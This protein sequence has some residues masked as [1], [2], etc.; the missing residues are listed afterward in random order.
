[1]THLFPATY[2]IPSPHAVRE[3]ILL[4]HDIGVV[5]DSRLHMSGVNDV[6]LVEAE[7]GCY[8]LKIYRAGWRSEPEVLY[9]L[10]LLAHL[11]REGISVALP[12]ARRDGR[13]VVSLPALEGARPCVLFEHAPGQQPTWP[14]YEDE[15]ESRLLGET[16]AAIH[17]A[18]E[19]F[20]S[21]HPRSPHDEASLLDRPLVAARPFLAHRP[22]DWDYLQGLTERLRERLAQ[23]VSRGL[24]W[25]ICHGDFHCGNAFI[26]GEGQVTVFDFDVC[27]AGWLAFDLARWKGNCEGKGEA[28]WSAF[29]QG[30][31]SRRRLE[32]ADLEAAPLFVMLRAF[33]WMRIKCGFVSSGAWGSWDMDYYFN[34][35][36]ALLKAREAEALGGC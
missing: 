4:D 2:S 6:Y 30:Y 32:A 36:L 18:G 5:S 28:S 8:V 34:D 3:I 19:T 24:S 7:T 27:G 15:A 9:E 12:V 13:R 20:A 16:L 35:T 26:T 1:M 29:L 31:Q 25:G 33:D 14:F 22:T 23:L 11:D 21:A 17:A 10:D